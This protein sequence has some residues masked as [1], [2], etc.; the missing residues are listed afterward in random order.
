MIVQQ[1]LHETK[2]QV[3][4][5]RYDTG[6][7]GCTKPNFRSLSVQCTGIQYNYEY[8][9]GMVSMYRYRPDALGKTKGCSRVRQPSTE[10]QT[11]TNEE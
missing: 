11:P 9:Q 10:V 8:M 6:T 2:I 1:L 7:V 3:Q 5:R 4:V